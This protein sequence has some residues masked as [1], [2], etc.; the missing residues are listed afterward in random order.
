[1]RPELRSVPGAPAPTGVVF[2]D[3]HVTP[4]GTTVIEV[5]RVRRRRGGELRT[6]A[7]GVYA[8]RDGKAVWS[9]AV[10]AD[11]IALIGVATGFVAAT[12]ATLAV[13]RQPPWPAL[14]GTISRALDR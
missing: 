3:P 1:M 7:L 6:S 13:L 14:T 12:L 10:D 8:I 4:D 2:A 9:P 5:S 11:R